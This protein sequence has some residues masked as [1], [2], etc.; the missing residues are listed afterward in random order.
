M[1]KK[2]KKKETRTRRIIVFFT[3]MYCFKLLFVKEIY[4]L[5]L[6]LLKSSFVFVSIIMNLL[7]L[8]NYLIWIV[9]SQSEKN[10]YIQLHIWL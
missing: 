4:H 7:S 6:N 5:V 1:K 10:T 3:F 8:N 9:F 2:L